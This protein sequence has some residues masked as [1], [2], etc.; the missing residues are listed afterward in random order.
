MCI[1]KGRARC[2]PTPYDRHLINA[3]VHACFTVPSM[4]SVT[5]RASAPHAT[6]C[7]AIYYSG[8]RFP[9]VGSQAQGRWPYGM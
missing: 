8:D 7:H 6:S 2:R 1:Q 9:G 3:R 4:L 5:C